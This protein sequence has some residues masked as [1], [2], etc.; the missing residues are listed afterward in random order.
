MK[1]MQGE[2]S[3]LM[4]CD[5]VLLGGWCSAFW[6]NV[7]P[8]SSKVIN[9]GECTVIFQTSGTT[10]Q[11]THCHIPKD[12]KTSYL[13]ASKEFE[14]QMLWGMFGRG[15]NSGWMKMHNIFIVFSKYSIYLNELTLYL[16]WCPFVFCICQENTYTEYVNFAHDYK[17]I[18]CLWD[19]GL[20]KHLVF[21]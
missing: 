1:N 12:L 7:V 14:N 18:P 9:E 11:R 10:H 21:L 17:A 19:D 4:S 5:F 6:R 8:S 13:T 3:G 15:R 2:D 20:G 16:S